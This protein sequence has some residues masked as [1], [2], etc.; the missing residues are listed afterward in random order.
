M[1]LVGLQLVYF[2][3]FFI[4]FFFLK[5]SGL[6]EKM[7]MVFVADKN[8]SRVEKSIFSIKNL[9]SRYFIGLLIQIT[10]LFVIY[11]IVLLIFGI[12]N[13]V[14]ISLVCALLNI[15]PFLGPIIGSFLMVFFNHDK[16]SRCQ[17]C[18]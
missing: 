8:T 12:P 16:S 13:A 7:V 1:D 9:L 18:N 14:T 4:S 2:Q 11:T 17:F 15:I 10:A 3:S 5:D 6:L